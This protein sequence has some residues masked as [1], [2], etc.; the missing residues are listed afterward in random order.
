MCKTFIYVSYQHFIAHFLASLTFKNTMWGSLCFGLI[1]VKGKVRAKTVQ[2]YIHDYHVIN[3][4]N[5]MH[6]IK[7]VLKLS[8]LNLMKYGFI[9][10]MYQ[11]IH[12]LFFFFF[13]T[14]FHSVLSKRVLCASSFLVQ[15]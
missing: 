9:S 15:I 5:R 7:T 1:C 12:L 13:F 4:L 6:F 11:C 2:M 8:R 3:C 14:F 10:K